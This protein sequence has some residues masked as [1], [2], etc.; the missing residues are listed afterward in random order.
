MRHSLLNSEEH[1]YSEIASKGMT[2]ASMFNFHHYI[3]REGEEVLSRQLNQ[4]LAVENKER[5]AKSLTKRHK[6][7]NFITTV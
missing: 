2:Q 6:L 5:A 3:S 4:I 7:H 1:R